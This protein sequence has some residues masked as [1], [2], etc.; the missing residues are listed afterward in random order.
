[1]DTDIIL[2]EVGNFGKY[3]IYIFFL[4]LL[5]GIY[6]TFF[7]ISFV[8]TAGDLDY[9]C[10]IEQCDNKTQLDK[11]I[12][13]HYAVP[14]RNDRPEKCHRFQPINTTFIEENI[15]E[16]C[17][18]TLFSRN[19]TEKCNHFIYNTDET[20][21]VTDF[22][23]QCEEN[24]WKRA[25]VGTAN[26]VGQFIGMPLSGII[27]DRY[28]RKTMLTMAIMLSVIMGLC[29]SYAHTY[30]VFVLFE[31]LDAIV[32][33]GTYGACFILGIEILA[34]KRRVLGSSIIASF[35]TMGEVVLGLLAWYLRD[36]RIYLRALYAPGILFVFYIWLV[37]ES[38]RWLIANKKCFEARKIVEKISYVNKK[39][40]TQELKKQLDHL[41]ED[42]NN[43][44]LNKRRPSLIEKHKGVFKEIIT[45][46]IMV[47]RTSICSFSWMTNAFVFYGLSLS[48]V[49]VAGNKYFNFILVSLAELPGYALTWIVLD[50]FGR[51]MSLF[52]A[53]A[54]SGISCLAFYFVPAE[55]SSMR[56][57]IFL[58]GKCAITVSFSV[59]YLF[60]SEIFPTKARHSLMGTCS[61]FGRV[62]SMMAPLTPLVASYIEPSLI[63]GI[64]ALTA[65][66]LG[67][68]FPETLHQPLPDTIQEAEVIGKKRKDDYD[69]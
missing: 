51:R 31:M 2:K 66:F 26:N 56:L 65:G 28:G 21:I 42:T 24:D 48:S 44:K 59:L 11:D 50:R 37:P 6:T 63:F 68:H 18:A 4:L 41:V 61:M 36:W 19:N 38:I 12:W 55:L 29:R 16:S 20:T 52:L 8:F 62:G 5:C 69:P 46:K 1:M 3:Q 49:S 58:I 14:F 43:K 30:E 15:L 54:I 25:A 64:A 67:L 22:N 35:Y 53:L 33:S 7:S 9:R 34:P 45:S 47:I 13:L 57:I 39:P 60:S 27:S 40:L 23:L 32:S 17:T 10:Y